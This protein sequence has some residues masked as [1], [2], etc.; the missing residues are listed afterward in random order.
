MMIFGWK[1]IKRN[2]TETPPG[3][4]GGWARASSEW[5]GDHRKEDSPPQYKVEHTRGRTAGLWGTRI[6]S[7]RV[8]PRGPVWTE[9]LSTR[10][11]SGVHDTIDNR[12]K[13]AHYEKNE[14]RGGR[15]KPGNL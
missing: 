6:K 14:D 5:G 4:R 2:S 3:A 13:G 10:G 9:V 1:S 11:C 7:S 8:Q 15:G 12:S